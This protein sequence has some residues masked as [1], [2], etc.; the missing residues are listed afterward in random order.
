MLH[1]S[2]HPRFKVLP[3][4]VE[5]RVRAAGMDQLDE[6]IDR[7]LDAQTLDDVFGSEPCH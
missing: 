7:I 3:S 4:G 5:D 2:G 6:W 1:D